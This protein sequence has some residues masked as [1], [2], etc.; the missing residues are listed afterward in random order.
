MFRNVP[1]CSRRL[2]IFFLHKVNFFLFKR[3]Y[4][5]WEHF[6]VLTNYIIINVK[7][8]QGTMVVVW[9]FLSLVNR[10]MPEF[11]NSMSHGIT[12]VKL[13]FGNG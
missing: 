6:H 13:E 3:K 12:M 7:G 11:P 5:F 4:I 9:G 10:T 2:C 1:E 8:C